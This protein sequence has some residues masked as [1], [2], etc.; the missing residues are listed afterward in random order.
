MAEVVYN[1]PFPPDMVNLPDDVDPDDVEI[2]A[3]ETGTRITIEIE[4]DDE[5]AAK[6][7]AGNS[8]NSG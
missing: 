7:Q 3:T 1:Y 8:G 2:E 5:T 4:V 6:L